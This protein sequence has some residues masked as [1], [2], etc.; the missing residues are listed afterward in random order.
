MKNLS[1]VQ[2]LAISYINIL[3]NNKSSFLTKARPYRKDG[4][5]F[6]HRR[7]NDNIGIDWYT[8]HKGIQHS[9]YGGK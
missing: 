7:Y 5:C 6:Y 1:N 8:G 2:E 3:Y 4:M 9:G